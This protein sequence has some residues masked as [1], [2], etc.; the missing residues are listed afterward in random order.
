MYSHLAPHLRV[1]QAARLSRCNFMAPL[2]LAVICQLFILLHQT[3]SCRI[4]GVQDCVI[5]L[6]LLI[7]T[8]RKWLIWATQ[9]LLMPCYH[10]YLGRW[11]RKRNNYMLYSISNKMSYP[12][13]LY[14]EKEVNLTFSSGL[15]KWIHCEVIA[16]TS[17][18]YEIVS[19]E[20]FLICLEN[21]SLFRTG[22]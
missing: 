12:V 21:L 19:G 9:C 4:E 14:V 6:A 13:W 8:C 22:V 18:L 17:K 7:W 3:G 15:T 1:V 16:L 20:Q 11:Q 10:Y 2:S 5:L